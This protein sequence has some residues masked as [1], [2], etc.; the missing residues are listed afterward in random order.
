MEGEHLGV[1]CLH[2]VNFLFSNN[3]CRDETNQA[4][5]LKVSD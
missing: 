1:S 4:S 2:D 3:E 5:L